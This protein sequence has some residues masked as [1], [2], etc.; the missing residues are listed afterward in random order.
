MALSS[1]PST[2]TVE[3]RVINAFV[4]EGNRFERQNHFARFAQEADFV[5]REA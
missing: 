3:R 2:Q 1:T 5:S 4:M